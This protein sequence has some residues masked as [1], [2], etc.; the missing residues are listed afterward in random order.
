MSSLG[1]SPRKA[2]KHKVPANTTQTLHLQNDD[3]DTKD[4]DL[5]LLLKTSPKLKATIPEHESLNGS[6]L[7]LSL[8]P[9]ESSSRRTRPRNYKRTSSKDEKIFLEDFE[10]STTIP[11]LLSN[12]KRGSRRFWFVALLIVCVLMVVMLYV[13][14]TEEGDKTGTMPNMKSLMGSV[15]IKNKKQVNNNLRTNADTKHGDDGP[16]AVG[17]DTTKSRVKK[18]PTPV[19][20]G[21]D[22]TIDKMLENFA[23]SRQALV[24]QLMIDYGAATFDKMF[25]WQYCRV[26]MQE[27]GESW[28]R[29][30]RKL[31]MKLLKLL[32]KQE[33]SSFVWGTGGHSIAAAHGN[34]YNQSYTAYMERAAGKVFEAVGIDFT[35]RNYAMGGE[36]SAPKMAA[37]IDEIFGL[38]LDFLLWDFSMMDQSRFWKLAMYVM[39]AGINPGRPAVGGFELTGGDTKKIF[40]DVHDMGLASFQFQDK[41]FR[42]IQTNVPNTLGKTQEEIDAMPEYVKYF[43]CGKLKESGDP[44]CGDHKYDDS[45]CPDRAFKASWHP[46]WYVVFQHILVP[47]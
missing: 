15:S 35:T 47:Y 44:G 16:V 32:L 30:K 20:T 11:S 40:E 19:W 24:D 4:P 25:S 5:D 46:G 22:Y 18:T 39:R 17:A 7:S 9:I 26:D 23:T 1:M 14:E 13:V 10:R 28:N 3:T 21:P 12:S 29:L 27:T 43:K 6:S 37:C 2:C 45:I 36:Q 42:Q 38:D 41:T 34:L 31:K 8:P 33:Q